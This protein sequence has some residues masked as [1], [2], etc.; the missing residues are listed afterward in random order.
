MTLKNT[1]RIPAV[2][3]VL[4]EKL[5]MYCQ[6]LP[7][8]GKI[9]PDQSLDLQLKYCSQEEAN[10]Q[11]EIQILIRGGKILKVPFTVN[12]IV[13]KIEIK[14]EGFNFGKITT[15]GN[16]G[17]LEMNLVNNSNIHATLVLD[18]RSE[19][20]NADSPDGIECL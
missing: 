6:I 16:C 7:L 2:F 20:E 1:S 12:V 4:S 17:V 14:E 3:K 13:P 10:V 8:S 18:M 19:E 9:M 5:P 15:L 11:S